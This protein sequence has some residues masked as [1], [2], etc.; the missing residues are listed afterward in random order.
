[1]SIFFSQLSEKSIHHS[2]ACSYLLSGNKICE[3]EIEINIKESK[4]AGGMEIKI[5]RGATNQDFDALTDEEKAKRLRLQAAAEKNRQFEDMI[6][7]A[8]EAWQK[9]SLVSGYFQY[10]FSHLSTYIGERSERVAAL[11]DDKKNKALQNIQEEVLENVA[12]YIV[13]DMRT[14]AAKTSKIQHLIL[15]LNV[16]NELIVVNA[17]NANDGLLAAVIRRTFVG[18]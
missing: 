5:N 10:A 17:L 6:E 2:D 14:D 12:R 3:I 8:I 18:L 11:S 13:K 9:L 7:T 16:E 4:M 15:N 1:L